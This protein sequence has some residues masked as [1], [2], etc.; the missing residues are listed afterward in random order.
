MLKSLNINDVLVTPYSA[1]KER[2]ISNVDNTDLILFE[3]TGSD[4]GPLAVAIEY[5]DFGDGGSDPIVN[6]SCSLA[7]ELQSLN[8]ATYREGKKIEG[9]F[10][11]DDEQ[12]RDSTYK[13]IVF[14]QVREMFYNNYRDPTKM[15]G[16]EEIDF[17]KS[18]TK[19]FLQ[20]KF[21]V[22]D[23]PTSVMG[24]KILPNSVL[25]N[26]QTSDD[27]YIISD[28]GHCNLVVGNNVFSKHQEL[29]EFTNLFAEGHSSLCDNYWDFNP[30]SGLLNLTASQVGVLRTASLEW[31]Y[32]DDENPLG[33]YFERS[34]DSGSTWPYSFYVTNGATRQTYDSTVVTKHTYWYR[35]YAYNTYGTS[36]WSN[37]AS[38]YINGGLLI[39]DGPHD[40]VGLLGSSV[41]FSVI[42]AGEEPVYYQWESGSTLLSDN[43]QITGSTTSSVLISPLYINHL[44]LENS[45][46]YRVYVWNSLDGITSSYANLTVLY[47][48]PL[49][50]SHPQD[51][52]TTFG[53]TASFFVSASGTQPLIW[54]WM[55]GSTNLTDGA[56]ITGSTQI[57]GYS[58]SLQIN[59]IILTD[60]ANYRVYVSNTGG[61]IYSN[62]ATLSIYNAWGE[63]WEIYSLG[64]ISTSSNNTLAF[65]ENGTIKPAD[66]GRGIIAVESINDYSDPATLDSGTG[67][68][69]PGIIN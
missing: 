36:S 4:G 17:D 67:W 45:G 33:F 2:H 50:I 28:D 22:L 60:V 12:N 27:K 25:I 6:S 49:I 57:G 32:S 29:G 65:S 51:V 48:A 35:T 15:W 3:H 37:T 68:D 66:R 38:V 18:Q 10:Y 55:S 30:P 64:A 69:G 47:D 46:T 14:S 43:Y 40:T 39:L 52:G 23:I 44:K 24:E 34:E 42:V 11:L 7:N 62:Y 21:V 19:K 41:S 56:R 13:R 58:S 1:V 53:N 5:I 8:L 61:N 59:N 26:D 63:D 31:Y 54:Q 20:D 9:T 16:M